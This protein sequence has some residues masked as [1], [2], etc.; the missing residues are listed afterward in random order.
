MSQIYK[1]AVGSTPSIP[2]SF[3]TDTG[4]AVPAANILNID[5]IDSSVYNANGITT[6]GSGNTVDVVLTN[7]VQ[8]TTSTVGA[9]TGDVITFAMGATPGTFRFDVQVCGF[10]STTP[11]GA[12]YGLEICARTTGAAATL[13]DVD[14][15]PQEEA[16]LSACSCTAVVSGNDLIVRITGSA[17]L[18]INWSGSGT[19][20]RAI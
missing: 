7:R 11:A 19:Y 1:S 17:G 16:A 20:E 3:V 2:T 14:V 4:S 12:G 13:I 9:V 6:T 10:E 8:G 15:N 18:T 5:G